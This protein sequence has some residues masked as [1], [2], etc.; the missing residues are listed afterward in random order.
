MKLD[1]S[2]KN[3][4][5]G[6]LLTELAHRLP[7]HQALVYPY[8]N[9][10]WNFARLEEEAVRAAQSL[11]ALGIEKG[12]RVAIW[13]TNTPEWIVL[14]FALAK[15]G[16]ILVTVNTA[17]GR[18]EIE[19]L[20][21]QSET[22]TLF[23]ISGFRDVNYLATLREIAPELPH[24]A[25]GALRSKNLPFLRR[26]IYLGE[27]TQPG[28]L[29]Y[30][31]LLELAGRVAPG[32]LS[33]REATLDVDGVI[34]MQYT[35]GTTGFPKGVMLSH[36]NIL[37]NGSYLGDGLGYTPSDRLCLAV[38]LFH[39]FGCVIGVL[40]AYTHGTTMIP[41]EFFDPR[42]VLEI[43]SR[44]R[45][46][47]IYGVPTM[48]IA[49]LE[50]PDFHQYDLSSLRTGVM[51][52]SLCPIE[53]MKQ[54]IAKM[55]LRELTIAY[56]LTEASPGVTQ[57]SRFDTLEKRTTT[58]GRAL[59]EVEVKIVDP[60]D[61]NTLEPGQQGELLTRGYHVMKG[62]YKNEAATRETITTE[63]WLRTGDLA[64]MDQE[65]YFVI[66]GRIKDM[67][68]RGGENIY[69]KEIEEYLRTHPAVS[70]VAVY[71]VPSSRYGEEV[72]AAVKLKPG[73]KMNAEELRRFCEGNL[74]RFKIP[75][76]IQFVESYPLTASG[77][78]QKFI[79]RER[80]AADFGLENVS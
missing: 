38:P 45:C 14:Q 53:L 43:V 20:L 65:G 12:D 48:F 1:L 30:S 9:L 44:E 49:V 39:C 18:R 79:L 35:S 17:L 56:G 2:Y 33:R 40:G 66:T 78:I 37:N 10:R 32:E 76:H 28:M 15:I 41:L 73:L 80:A 67:I 63:G 13:A 71:G 36:R 3:C 57:T 16:A 64:S 46:T 69:P 72:A 8:R 11:L 42:Q 25:F 4:T 52:G 29:R 58:V 50:H 24:Q 62:Y 23:L 60:G 75:K 47:A 22:S 21:A 5:V 26:V 7:D 31:D 54:A 55:H 61:G 77:K 27:E 19:Y 51:A 68:I 6:N 59:P 74:S 70:D 34:N